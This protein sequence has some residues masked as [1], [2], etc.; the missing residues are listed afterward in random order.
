MMVIMMVVVIMMMIVIMIKDNNE[1]DDYGNDN[2][3]DNDVKSHP[4]HRLINLQLSPYSSLLSPKTH[5]VA[6]KGKEKE[7]EVMKV[8][9]MWVW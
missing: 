2:M 6:N 7:N 5:S 4:H 1:D 3:D 9:N 8:V